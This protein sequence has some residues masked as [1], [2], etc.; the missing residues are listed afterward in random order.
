VL[1][2]VHPE[3]EIGAVAELER[4]G[5]DVLVVFIA[6]LMEV[7]GDAVEGG[8]GDV[9]PVRLLSEIGSYSA[10]VGGQS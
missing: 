6:G 5:G 8:A 4:V 10:S 2:G 9:V 1:G 7:G 3:G